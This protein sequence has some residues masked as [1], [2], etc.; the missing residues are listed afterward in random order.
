MKR[1][2][3]MYI[4]MA[5]FSLYSIQLTAG[6]V[7]R[8]YSEDFKSTRY[9]DALNTSASWDTLRGEMKLPP[10][11]IGLIGE[12]LAETPDASWGIVIV[13]DSAFVAD[14][15]A[16]VQLFDISDPTGPVHR[17]RYLTDGEVH[18]L[19]VYG[20]FLY[21]A[22]GD[23]G[24]DIV[25]R[26]LLRSSIYD[27]SKDDGDFVL[28]GAPDQP[29]R[30]F[31]Y[32][33]PERPILGAGDLLSFA[34]DIKVVKDS[35][36]AI[37]NWDSIKIMRIKSDN[38][39][40]V[41]RVFDGKDTPYGSVAFDIIG[42]D[43][44]VSNH[45]EGL[46]I[47]YFWDCD[48][49]VS[50][51]ETPGFSYGFDIEGDYLYMADGSAGLQVIDISDLENPFI[52]ATYD[53]P[54]AAVNVTVSGDFAYVSDWDEGIEV[55][56]ISDP[57]TP[58]LAG[59]SPVGEGIQTVNWPWDVVIRGDYAF[60]AAHTNGLSVLQIDPFTYA[61]SSYMGQSLILDDSGEEVKSVKIAAV[62]EGTVS[63]EISADNGQHWQPVDADNAW[64]DIDVPGNSL[65]WRAT[66]SY[67][68]DGVISN[69]SMLNIE[70]ETQVA[71]L[72]TM[73]SASLSGD[74]I[75]L[76]WSVSEIAEGARFV[77]YRG[78]YPVGDQE[79][80][81]VIDAGKILEYSYMD[82]EWL[83]GE[84]YQYSVHLIDGEGERLLFL[85]EPVT[86]P[87]A[88]LTL[89]QNEPNPFNPS[90]TIRY[91]L[92]S[93]SHVTI[94][95]YDVSGRHV[96]RI[97][98]KEEDEGRHSIVWNGMDHSSNTVSSGVYFYV[99]STGKNSITKKMVLLR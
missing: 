76:K 40:L 37:A 15:Y 86:V 6:E 43:I 35:L 58:V 42:D 12:F 8:S 65:L 1:R 95:I 97:L 31:E 50:T 45:G 39:D 23:K 33:D 49:V 25:N 55:V 7:T 4:I 83:S 47:I 17:G 14:G 21:I 87:G 69:C 24:Y 29:S 98:N 13:G 3:L 72:L 36:L 28:S 59:T 22:C 19:D 91:E 75:E 96:A 32:I 20:D 34:F 48:S 18:A 16:G 73:S 46:E 9:R 68:D 57:L 26:N 2:W 78:V 70:W 82:K 60:A 5:A 79:K 84:S 85:T 61:S 64:H 62:E 92:P 51:L 41:G 11:Q 88:I 44:F 27:G 81:A 52:A 30:I 80:I 93:K 90:T 71:T 56:D 63:W 74:F 54:G 77:V 94:D 66:L 67:L 53:T 89:L 38:P 99:L 10:F